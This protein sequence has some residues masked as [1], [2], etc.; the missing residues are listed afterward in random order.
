MA[1]KLQSTQA[2]HGYA[3]KRIPKVIDPN[4]TRNGG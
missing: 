4:Q 1:F 2:L 3:G